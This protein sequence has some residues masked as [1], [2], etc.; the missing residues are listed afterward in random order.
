MASKL[1]TKASQ[2]LSIGSILCSLVGCTAAATPA[3]EP[4]ATATSTP[5]VCEPSEIQKTD[6]GMTEIQGT[7]HSDGE[8]WALLFFGTPY[9]DGELKIVWRI[10][11][12]GQ[13]FTVEAR[14]EDGTVLEP[15][16]GPQ[17]HEDS[18][19]ERPGEEWGTSF[20]FPAPGCWTVIATRGATIGEI[21]LD[22]V[23]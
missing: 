2:I 6:N 15:F 19:W 17:Y 22:V 9:V 20:I 13:D 21:R 23:K 7:M 4:T 18:T 16:W 11:G 8:V 5:V 3:P 14:H 12:T 10:T 1:F